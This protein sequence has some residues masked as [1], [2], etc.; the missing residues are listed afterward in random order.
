MKAFFR[1]RGN[2]QFFFDA[3]ETAKFRFD[4]TLFRTKGGHTDEKHKLAP[5]FT[6]ALDHSKKGIK[7]ASEAFDLCFFSYGSP[8]EL[9]LS[10]K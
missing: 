3:K 7:D 1:R 2:A 8:A 9:G 5:Y 6:S 10:E 4:S